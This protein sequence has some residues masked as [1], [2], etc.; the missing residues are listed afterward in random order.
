[1]NNKLKHLKA[2]INV[3]R[4]CLLSNKNKACLKIRVWRQQVWAQGF[5]TIKMNQNLCHTGSRYI[6]YPRESNNDIGDP[7]AGGTVS[8]RRGSE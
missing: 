4:F 7:R 5:F 3:V 1:M 2:C 6:K 8:T